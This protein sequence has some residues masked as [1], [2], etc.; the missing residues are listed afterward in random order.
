M[1]SLSELYTAFD[2]PP[3]RIVAFLEHLVATYR[4]PQPLRVLDIGCGPGRLLRPL[5]RLGWAV[6]GLEPNPDF[7]TAAQTLAQSSRHLSVRQGG[8]LDVSDT[9]GF[10]LACAVNS[11]FAHLLH[12]SERRSAIERIFDALLPGGV[13]FLDLPNCLWILRH[14]RDA[15]PFTALVQGQ[16]VSLLRRQEVDYHA[17]TITTTDVYVAAESSRPM[18]ELVHVYGI[19]TL[20][21]IE[22]LCRDAGFETL[23][24]FGSYDA[25]APERLD[26]ARLLVSARKPA[27]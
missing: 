26:G 3:H 27:G 4:L 16:E 2:S 8:F 19:T 20:P 13:M 10:H 24:T 9:E 7:V 15:D 1:P 22:S 21:E 6:V 25:R 11:S 5:E 18:A 14:H 17:A 12:P 23:H